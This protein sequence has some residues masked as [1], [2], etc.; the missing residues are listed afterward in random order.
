[1]NIFVSVIVLLA[2]L[3]GVI[4]GVGG[5]VIIK[6]ILDMISFGS[7]QSITFYS[8]IS[9]ISMALYNLVKKKDQILKLDKI[10]IIVVCLSSTMGGFI[11][12]EILNFFSNIVGERITNV[13]S[14]VTVTL[15]IITFYISMRSKTF[16]L[17]RTLISSLIF[18]T[19]LGATSAFLGIGG[20]PFNV[21]VFNNLL[22]Y[23]FTTSALLSIIVII[24]S[25]STNLATLI[26]QNGFS[27]F[28]WK[29]GLF[30]GFSALLG[31][32]IAT[33]IETKIN[34]FWTKYLF[35]GVLMFLIILNTYNYYTI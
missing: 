33:K 3:V 24:F 28:D 19:I 2:S 35:L 6:P 31:S 16:D 21:L 17:P 15:L 25:Q 22:A 34:S 10:L 8:A 4:T 11:G 26:I 18:G 32:Y 27:S 7:R 30:L 12:S 23:P 20:G 1:M 5:G 9:V 14:L 13:Q 29:I